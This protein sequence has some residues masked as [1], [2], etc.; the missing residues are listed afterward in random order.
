[1]GVR[2]GG[3][4]EVAVGSVDTL[5]SRLADPQAVIKT[6]ARQKTA[7]LRIFEIGGLDDRACPSF[8]VPG[9]DR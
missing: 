2:V 5:S 9:F 4:V 3:R 6:R 8:R 1:M 7:D